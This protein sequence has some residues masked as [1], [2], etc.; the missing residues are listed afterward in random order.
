MNNPQSSR[1]EPG[2]GIQISDLFCDKAQ[3]R[4]DE[5]VNLVLELVNRGDA[6]IVYINIVLSRLDEMVLSIAEKR[7]IE[8]GLQTLSIALEGR[9]EL[10]A[11]FGIDLTISTTA[12]SELST[13]S[14]IVSTAFDVAADPNSRIRYGFLSDFASPELGRIG[15][16]K[17]LTKLHINHV[18]FYDWMYRHDTLISP[19]TRYVDP[20]GKE[21]DLEVVRE[22]IAACHDAGMRAIAYGAVYA[23]TSEFFDAHPDWALYH[24]NGAAYCFIDRFYIMDISRDSQWSRHIVEQFHAVTEQLGFDGIHMDTYGFPKS[25][26]SHSSET[27]RAAKLIFLDQEFPH[28][29]ERTR[30][31]LGKERTLIFNNVG[32]WP[33][34]T[35]G[36]A[37]QNAVYIEVWKPFDRYHHLVEL[38]TLGRRCGRG[39]PVILA[40]YLEPFKC[41]TGDEELAAAEQA[42][43]LATAVITTA[44]GYH[45]LLG[46]EGGLLMQAYYVDHAIARPRFLSQIRNYYDFII[47]YTDILFDESMIDVTT[48]HLGVDFPDY[49]VTGAPLSQ[50]GEAGMVWVTVRESATRKLLIFVNLVGIA[51]DEWNVGQKTPE[52]RTDLFI[53]AR[54]P[55]EVTGIFTASPDIDNARP[56]PLAFSLA[57]EFLPSADSAR[58]NAADSGES[59]L[60]EI[61]ATTLPSLHTWALVVINLAQQ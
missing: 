41:A 53:Q 47:R 23:A 25:A 7:R 13:S 50:T 39:K 28:L 3:Y 42:A 44:G 12:E 30:E 51:T 4:P 37:P 59:A 19:A 2:F 60:A 31:R 33:V 24:R 6:Q 15:D 26:F 17:L 21:G 46:E 36:A 34:E 49:L 11:A 40:A 32:G 8:T 20:M 1:A 43:L 27:S 54:I 58:N 14:L 38:I 52:P 35:T 22:K 48:S 29:I 57:T 55:K 5:P 45:L 9:P 10:T 61:V 16:V 18:Q 56:Q